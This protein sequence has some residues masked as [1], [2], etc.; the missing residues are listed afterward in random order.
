M[1]LLQALQWRYATKKFDET[2]EVSKEK[3]DLLK[4]AFNLTA[5]SYGLQP[6]QLVVIKNKAIQ[7]DL[8]SHSYQQQ[9][10]AQA[11]HLLVICIETV[12]DDRYIDKH[13]EREI[14]I[15]GTDPEI[16]KPFET[17]LKESFGAK[18]Q[19]DIELWATKQ[20]YI[21]LGTLLTACAMEEIDACPME[22]FIPSEYD[23]LLHLKEKNLKSV[24]V[25]PVGY[26]AEDDIFSDF[27][28]VRKKIDELTIFVDKY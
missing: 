28:K 7:K 23:K 12:I 2:K 25:L 15:R 19:E 26:R 8:V 11:S 6:L 1:D 22:G 21:A 17:H 24:L 16:L 20:A 27:Q 10:V 5:T 13:F 18:K 3:I 9:Q 4:K 14:A